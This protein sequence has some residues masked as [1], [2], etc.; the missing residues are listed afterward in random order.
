MLESFE[1][2]IAFARENG[3]RAD[4]TIATQW[5][6]LTV[7]LEAFEKPDE[8]K[9]VSPLLVTLWD[10]DWPWNHYCPSDPSGPGGHVYA[11]CGAVAMAQV[12]K[13]WSHPVQGEGQNSYYHPD[14]GT[15]SANFGATTYDWA[16]MS[17]TNATSA[18]KTLLYHCGVA[19]Y[20]DY[21][22][23]GSGA[24][25]SDLVPAFENFFRYDNDANFKW[26]Q[27][28]ASST[29]ENLVRTELDNGRP[30]V[31][32]GY[33]TGGHAFN[34]DGYQGTNHFHFNWGW[35]GYY[36]GYYYLN[37]LTPGG[38]NFTNDQGGVFNLFPEPGSDTTPPDAIADL[39][40]TTSGSDLVLSWS[41][42]SDNVGVVGYWIYQRA[43]AFGEASALQYVTGAE[44]LMHTV[45]D[46]CGDAAVNYFYDV[47]AVDAAQNEAD[48]SNSVGEFDLSLQ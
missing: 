43:S 20:M 11:G 35:S 41:M 29:W 19:I 44:T 24:Y 9:S 14:Y 13:Y 48:P 28:Y 30:L 38:Y 2:Q 26:K 12:M 40:A 16:N 8:V 32:I 5:K 10:Q 4:E 1:E 31:Y 37:D 3:L 23:N 21:G 33:G 22:P 15:Q 17:N 6:R 34:L 39:A 47:R 25:P 18:S 7:P 36:N 45:Q 27:Y 42:P 46:V